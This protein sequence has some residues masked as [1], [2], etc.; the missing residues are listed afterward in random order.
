MKRWQVTALVLAAWLGSCGWFVARELAPGWW[1]RASL[2]YASLFA[3][4][5][6]VSDQWMRI[7]L[8]GKPVGYSHTQVE[9]VA[10][11]PVGRYRIENTTV[12]NVQVMGSR[13]RVQVGARAF[14][15]AMY[16]L[17]EFDFSLNAGTYGAGITGRR[18]RGD[19][20]HVIV[21]T[22]GS[23]E[24]LRLRIADDV[25]VYSPMMELALRR[26]RPGQRMRMKTFNPVSLATEEIAVRAVREEPLVIGGRTNTAM[27]LE[28]DYQGMN[29][30]TWIDAAGRMLRQQTPFGWTLEACDAAA[31]LRAD[32]RAEDA[33]DLLTMMAVRCSA[34]IE[35]ARTRAAV[36]LVLHGPRIP[37]ETLTTHRQRVL[38]EEP[39]RVEL[40]CRRETLPPRPVS[41]AA[42]GAAHPEA[43]VSSPFVQASHP[44]IRARAR[45]I[46][47]GAS[48][49]SLEVALRIGRWVHAEVRKEPAMSVP[50]ALDV[51]RVRAGDCNEHTY[52]FTALA[53]AAGVPTRIMVGLVYLEGAFYYHAWPA[54]FVG[55]WMELDPTLGQDAADATHLRLTEGELRDQMKLMT[56][57]GRLSI[58]LLPEPED[59]ER[60][61][62]TDA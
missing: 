15:D 29:V 40:E 39:G 62:E 30:R 35:A 49:D 25:V 59:G 33:G 36:R 2:N 9:D 1:S 46:V 50:S 34:P 41:V 3:D 14:L 38:R 55:R 26:L 31:A 60:Q 4:G 7:L 11:D 27:L 37:G 24:T 22:G 32:V 44:D 54:V 13:Q 8:R 10:E 47:G 42:A 51:L 17:Q 12:L 61:G 23:S 56:V 20:F 18:V 28:A 16:H 52:L 53:R 45:A 43:L 58:E 57:L 5:L 48:S 21:R 6:L 19:A